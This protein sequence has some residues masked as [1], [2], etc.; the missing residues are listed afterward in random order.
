MENERSKSGKV[1]SI[2]SQQLQSARDEYEEEVKLCLFRLKSLKRGQSRSL[3]TQ[4]AHHHAA[5]VF[6]KLIM[7]HI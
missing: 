4:T 6:F 7:F 2:T 1:E 3:L 5:Q